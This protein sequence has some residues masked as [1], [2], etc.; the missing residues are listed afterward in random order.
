MP[1]AVHPDPAG[2]FVL[3]TITDPYSIDEW[4]RGLEAVFREPLFL[5][6]ARVLVDRRSCAPPTASA[7]AEMV[8]FLS[9]HRPEVATSRTAVVVGD[10][11]AFGFWRMMALR[12]ELADLTAEIKVFREYDAGVYWLTTGQPV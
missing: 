7:V 6:R 11:A 12:T 4:R 1:V 8:D 2:R 3:L 9:E 10:E 5:K